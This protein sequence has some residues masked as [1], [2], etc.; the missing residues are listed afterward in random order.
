MRTRGLLVAP[1]AA[2][3]AAAFITGCG[4]AHA[5][6]GS[7]APTAGGQPT[8]AGAVQVSHDHFGA[9]AE[10]A[11]AVNPRNPRNLLAAARDPARVC[12]R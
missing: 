2:A 8:P 7:P 11:V 3:L 12:T 10:P 5:T 9:H 6:A 1:A 4:P